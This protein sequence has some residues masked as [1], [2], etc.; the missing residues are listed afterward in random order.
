MLRGKPRLTRRRFLYLSAAL[1]VATVVA[2]CS[3][4][5][6]EPLISESV[7]ELPTQEP[8][9][10]TPSPTLEP[11][12]PPFVVPEG[13]QQRLLMKG[14]P[15]ETPLYVFGSGRPGGV[16]LVLGGVHGNEPGGWLAAE[17]LLNELRPSSGALLLVPKANKL[18]TQAYVRTTDALGDLNRLYPGDPNGLPMERMAHEIVQ[19]V[20][21]FHVDTLVD[22][23]ESWAFYKDRPQNGTAY[24]GQ[25]IATHPSEPGM[26]TAR[27]LVD[28]VNGRVRN[29]WEEFFY[30]EFPPGRLPGPESVLPLD[31]SGNPQA[32]V[33]GGSRSSLGL[34]AHIPGLMVL[35]VEMGQQQPLERRVALHIEVATE[36]ARRRGLSA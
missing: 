9:A 1:P 36:V 14:T 18:A 10:P 13:Q 4:V 35:L 33:S 32:A 6:G 8:P 25:T 31:T 15:Q 2:A 20:H 5:S 12:P 27:T 34:P 30:R 17:R 26:S 22:M 7:V 24:L 29:P 11:P 3:S 23:H 21:E 16:M 28:A 19:T